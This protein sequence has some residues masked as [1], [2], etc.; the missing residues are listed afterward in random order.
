M[1][2]KIVGVIKYFAKRYFL[3]ALNGCAL[4][5]FS[6]LIIGLIISQI[7]KLTG[8]QFLV[9]VAAIFG[10]SSNL[11]GAAIGG[12]IAVKM[13]LKP[14]VVFSSIVVGGIG[15]SYGGILGAYFA[16]IVGGEIGNLVCQRTKIDI[17]VTPIFTILSGAF[18][19]YLVGAPI[20]ALM[21]NLGT[22]INDATELQP[23]PM[24][25][26]ISVMMGM[27]LTAPI[28]SAAIAMAIGLDGIAAGAAAV[29]CSAQMIG[30]AIC[31]FKKNGWGGLLSVGVGTSMLQFSN[32][33]RKP[34]I[35][36]PTIIVS[37][38][39]GPISTA[40]L[41]MINTKYGAGMGTSGFVGQFEGI[42]A[43]INNGTPTW[44]AFVE[45]IGMHII[46]PAILVYSI[47][48]AFIKLG[49]INAS[50]YLLERKTDVVIVEKKVASSK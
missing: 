39:L 36:L 45:V 1:I 8:V 32:I 43:M 6:S 10:A 34:I 12:A 31:S 7:G 47:N 48:E 40:V 23:I 33:V 4:G 22:I 35:W 16:A 15:Y 30:F 17:I 19:A 14:M 41:G 44:L 42:V 49:W 50:D 27:I 13:K 3:D 28:S 29:G 11:V 38:I 2:Q 37:A 26:V 46:V 21:S 24:G 5:L 20:A 9:D 18:I 25:I